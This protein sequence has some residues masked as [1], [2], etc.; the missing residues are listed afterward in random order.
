MGI[1]CTVIENNC[2]KHGTNRLYNNSKRL[3]EAENAIK[4]DCKEDFTLSKSLVDRV[5]TAS[6]IRQSPRRHKRPSS[7]KVMRRFPRQHKLYS[8]NANSRP[9]TAKVRLRTSS[10]S[11]ARDR[12]TQS[13]K[14]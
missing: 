14:K 1:N 12:Y 7:A 6:P 4:G 2:D 5:P 10:A 11:I 13:E 9:Q 3:V 8:S